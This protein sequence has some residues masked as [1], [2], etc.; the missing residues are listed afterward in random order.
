MAIVYLAHDVRHDREVAIKVLNRDLAAVVGP[1][2]FIAEIRTTAHFRHPHILPLFDSGSAD[3]LPYYVMPFVDGESL[4]QRLSRAVQ[5][6]VSEAVAMLRELADALAY[7][8]AAGVIHRDVKPDNVLL[9]GRHVFLADFGV[10]RAVA[11]HVTRDQ[12]VTGTSMMVGTPAYMAP[13]QLTGD[14]VDA[15]ADVYAFGVLAYELLTGAPPFRGTRQEVV[16]AHLTATP[17]PIAQAR[18]ETPP[19]LADAVMRCLQ[20]DPGLRWQRIDDLLPVLDTPSTTTGV[21]TAASHFPRSRGRWLF[22]AALTLAAALAGGYFVFKQP[23]AGGALAVGRLNRVTTE[24]GLEMDPAVSPDGRAIAYAA[25]VPGE[26]RIYVRQITGGRMTPLTSESPGAR[27][28]WPQ[29]SSDGSRIVYQQ[30]RPGFA[31]RA[32]AGES[33]LFAVPVIGGIAERVSSA[34][35]AVSPVA[36][37]W[38]PDDR[39]LAFGDVDGLYVADRS[40]QTPAELIVAQS[41]VHSPAW[42]PDGQ[43]IAFVSRALGFTFGEESLGNVE[44]SSLYVVN[45]QTRQITRVTNG[46]WLDVNPVWMPDGRS[47]LF[48]SSR[49]GGRDVFRQR[50]DRSG[51]LDGE[52]ERISS[53]LNAHGMSLSRDGRL[54]AYSSYAPRANIWSVDIPEGR[55]ASVR[56]ARQV[57]F[58]S[59]KIEKLAV[60]WDGRWLAYDSDRNGHPA[61]WKMPLAGGSPEPVTRGPNNEFVNDWSPDGQELVIHSM[62]EGGQRDVMV[63]SADGTKVEAVTTSPAEEQHAAFGPDGNSIVFDLSRSNEPNDLYVARRARRGS[64]WQAAVRLTTGGSSDP[65]WSPD[66]RLIAYSVRGALI[67]ITPDGSGRRVVVSPSPEYPLLA[68]PIWSRDSRTIYYKAYDTQL[69]KSIWA[70]P[71]TGGQPRLLVA[72]DDPARRSLR[73]EF[74]TDGQRFYFTIASDESDIW[75]LELISK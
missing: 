13:E 3:G 49:G 62:R 51:A 69:H 46:D 2:R 29:W 30:G 6:P 11:A 4:R 12:T 70:V 40:G 71:A 7:A 5:L 18:A 24:P 1:D 33:V 39:R 25:G 9:A 63:V 57:T 47:I 60:S 14:P 48:I 26:T 42:S 65:K 31:R 32:L 50:L 64:P 53:G 67:V 17:V 8:H 37:A 72:F 45:V 27:Q 59:E 68:Y 52:P 35:P 15:R 10:A 21:A 36:P 28:R 58:G 16:T 54:L 73:R 41:E 23:R 19:A 74:A 56:E 66:G 20:K 38:S 61:V 75:T 22:A 34:T 43:R 55:V 44:T